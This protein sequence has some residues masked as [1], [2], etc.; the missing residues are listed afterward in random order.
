MTSALYSQ[1]S[2]VMVSIYKWFHNNRILHIR[3]ISNVRRTENELSKRTMVNEKCNINVLLKEP[4]Q[5][6]FFVNTYVI[7]MNEIGLRFYTEREW[8]KQNKLNES[9]MNI[10]S[11]SW[12]QLEIQCEV[13]FAID[14]AIKS[15]HIECIRMERAMKRMRPKEATK[16]HQYLRDP[17]PS[18]SVTLI[19]F[20]VSIDDEKE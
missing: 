9:Q 11:P 1:C 8:E 17:W 20:S 15:L 4:Y 16:V 5:G 2:N 14:W 3:N 19:F 6:T 13:Y 18:W 10:S 12:N 7:S